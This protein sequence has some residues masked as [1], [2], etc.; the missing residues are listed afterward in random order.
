[1]ALSRYQAW[2]FRTFGGVAE[3][4]VRDNP[5]LR[6]SL[7]RAHVYLRPEAY[8][9]TFLMT[10]ALGASASAVPA[11]TIGVLFVLGGGVPVN[12]LLLMAPMPLLVA[13][14]LYA[15]AFIQP[16]MRAGS[17]ARDIDAKVPYALNYIATMASSGA[18]PD[19]IFDSLSR[20]PVY[21]EIAHEAALIRRDMQVLG[22]DILTALNRAIDRSPSVKWQDVMQGAITSLTSGGDL[23][24]YFMNKAEQ[25]MLDNRQEQTAFLETLGV[26]AESFVT[27]VV[28]APLFLL[29]MLSVMTSF[30][31]DA[32]QMLSIGYVLILALL[33]LAQ[34]GFAFTVKTI[35]P[36]A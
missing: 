6:M 11:I 14:A 27:V 15:V 20:Q 35:T 2:S 28:A 33:P 17:R 13:L 7:Q 5:R 36:E 25:F 3:R 18:T 32:A 26:L 30:G 24:L 19:R 16:E 4:L 31:A 34:F 29:V 8:L 1:M 10:M 23:K 12:L 21:G 22:H 9:A